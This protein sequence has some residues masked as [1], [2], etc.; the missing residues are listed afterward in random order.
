MQR[1]CQPEDRG[2]WTEDKGH[3]LLFETHLERYSLKRAEFIC[4][5]RS[6][7]RQAITHLVTIPLARL[8]ILFIIMK[9]PIET[10]LSKKC[11][12]LNIY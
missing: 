7:Q 9:I 11:S 6:A 5:A 3:L 8:L 4:K 12:I 2:H 10:S 1:L